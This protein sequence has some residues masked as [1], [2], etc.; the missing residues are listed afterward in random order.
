MAY[1]IIFIIGILFTKSEKKKDNVSKKI[2]NVDKNLCENTFFH[3]RKK[4][5][6]SI[7]WTGIYVNLKP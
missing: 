2:L 7:L 3:V 4:L 1:I 5:Y 6:F